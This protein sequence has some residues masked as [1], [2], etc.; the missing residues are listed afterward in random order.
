MTSKTERMEREYKRAT[1]RRE[2]AKYSIDTFNILY[3][4]FRRHYRENDVYDREAYCEWY[5]KIFK[6]QYNSY[7]RNVRENISNYRKYK[8]YKMILTVKSKIASQMRDK[9]MYID[10]RH[11]MRPVFKNNMIGLD[12]YY[13]RVC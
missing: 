12:N 10:I 8:P 13:R 1:L 7:T 2:Y 4:S 3:E 6:P 5:N 9:Y 11:S